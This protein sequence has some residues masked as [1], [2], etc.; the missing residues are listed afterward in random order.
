MDRN[1]VRVSRSNPRLTATE[2][3]REKRK[4][5]VAWAPAHLHWSRKEW[6]EVL[7]SDESKYML[8][9]SDGI[10]WIRRPDSKRYDPKYLLPTVKHGGG[11]CLVWGCFSAREMGPLYHI[12]GTMDRHVYIDILKNVMLPYASQSLQPGFIYQEDNDPKHRSKDVQAWFNHHQVTRLDWPSQSPDLNIIEQLWDES[13]RRLAG[14]KAMLLRNSPN[15][16]KNGR[17]SHRPPL[18]P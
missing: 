14:R 16:K 2:I 10:K 15:L 17:K 4:A 12:Q 18:T 7:W 13:E 8:F 9:R 6:S 5:R 11:S 1:I 3:A